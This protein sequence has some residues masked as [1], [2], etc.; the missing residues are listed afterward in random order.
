MKLM[1]IGEVMAVCRHCV[2]SPSLCLRK[3]DY[4]EYLGVDGKIILKWIKKWYRYGID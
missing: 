4:L 2:F 1:H 3:R